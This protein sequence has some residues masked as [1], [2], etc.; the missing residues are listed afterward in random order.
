MHVTPL[1]HWV[2]LNESFAF[3]A[4]CVCYHHEKWESERALLVF[5]NNT[6]EEVKR[7]GSQDESRGVPWHFT[8]PHTRI[9]LFLQ[10]RLRPQEGLA[11]KFTRTRVTQYQAISSIVLTLHKWVFPR[12]ILTKIILT[13]KN[14]NRKKISQDCNYSLQ[15]S[16]SQYNI[17]WWKTET[18]KIKHKARLSM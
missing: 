6:W 1:M 10:S 8:L 12:L 15:Q 13:P 9:L 18:P 2:T 17:Q 4:S 3:F 5:S 7:E 16:Q 11:N 14:K